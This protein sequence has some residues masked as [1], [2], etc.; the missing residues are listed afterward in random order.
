MTPISPGRPG[1]D[2]P[3][4][5]GM[6]VGSPSVTGGGVPE[7][8]RTLSLA[9]ARLP[10]ISPEIFSLEAQASDM[11]DFGDIPVHLAHP[12]GPA[13]F[14]YA[15]DLDGMIA[16]R[17]LDVLHVHGLWMYLSVAALRWH[18]RTGRPYVVSPHGMLDPWA[19]NSRG[20]KK[21][22]AR[23]LYEDAHLDNAACIH[24]LCE[25]EK[26]AV[27][28]AGIERPV[29]V[30][31][32]GVM[33]FDAVSEP[34]AW[35]AALPSGAKVLLFLGRLTPKK[36]VGPLIRA[37]SRVSVN[38][39][40]WH[41]VLVGPD[42]GDY[43]ADL[44]KLAGSGIASVHVVGPAY[45]RDKA[46]AY[47]SAT[48]F[49]LPSL[50]EGLPLAP[51]EAMSCG[52]PVLLTPECNLPEAFEAGCAIPTGSDETTIA[53]GLGRLM[54]MPAEQLSAMGARGKALVAARFNW[55]RIADSFARL[56]GRIASPDRACPEAL[57]PDP[58]DYSPAARSR[59]RHAGLPT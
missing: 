30:L 42:E 26:A 20:W 3:L 10:G 4:R 38:H 22:L 18:R 55:D 14:G 28:A 43:S 32:N 25:S 7:A 2:R 11:L 45:G 17:Q 15:A 23:R 57:E 59:R 39:P 33:D 27:R 47:A 35:R 9:L 12:R 46:R 1:Q 49:I 13:A 36:G 44:E 53:D 24:A 37:W 52:L 21:R 56:Y 19:L 54:T 40:D 51:L 41:L 6:L 29:V 50:S 34:A 5:I 8:M 31:P 58:D 48:A 16:A